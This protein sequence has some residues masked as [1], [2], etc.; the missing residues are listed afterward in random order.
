MENILQKA[1]KIDLVYAIN[2]PA[3]YGGYAAL[4]AAGREKGVTVVAVDGGCQGVKWVK[5]GIIGATAQQYPLLMASRGVEAVAEYIKTGK[6]PTSMDTGEKL[7]TDHP[8][9]G[10]PSISVEEGMKLCWG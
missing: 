9:P 4:K 3:A 5:E 6:K 10:V 8:V 1:D 7:V 2:E